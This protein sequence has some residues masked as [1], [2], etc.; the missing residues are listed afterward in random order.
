MEMLDE[1]GDGFITIADVYKF[2][3]RR[4]RIMSKGF[5]LMDVKLSRNSQERDVV[6]GAVTK[7]FSVLDTKK[8]GKL[9]VKQMEA[10]IRQVTTQMTIANLGVDPEEA[11]EAITEDSDPEF[12]QEICEQAKEMHALIDQDHDGLISVEEWI[13]YQLRSNGI[14]K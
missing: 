14:E 5:S 4:N 11:F 13:R 10:F 6:V 2:L 1:D 9:T 8:C 7:I 12:E 3:R